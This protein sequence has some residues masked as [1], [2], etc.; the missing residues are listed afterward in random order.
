MSTQ[1]LYIHDCNGCKFLGHTTC[2]DNTYDIYFCKHCDGG[3]LIAR[4][5]NDGP[6]YA[7]CMISII[8]HALD[9]MLQH[10]YILG[11]AYNQYK[12][13]IDWKPKP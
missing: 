13:Q 9:H 10:D 4:Y 5:G 8:Y 7:S 2:Q 1:P 6:E 12:D 11:V 3:S